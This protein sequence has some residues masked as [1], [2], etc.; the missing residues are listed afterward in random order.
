MRSGRHMRD[1][2]SFESA[3]PPAVPRPIAVFALW[4]DSPPGYSAARDS[5]DAAPAAEGAVQAG[6]GSPGESVVR[7]APT[8]DSRYIAPTERSDCAPLAARRPDSEQTRPTP[9]TVRTS[10]ERPFQTPGPVPVRRPGQAERP[11]APLPSSGRVP[12]TPSGRSATG[13]R[14][15]VCPVSHPGGRRLVRVQS[16]PASAEVG[17]AGRVGKR[18][19]PKT[20]SAGESTS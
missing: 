20:S 8:P 15:G 16:T 7:P 2:G 10:F 3:R 6:P 4:N 13:V 11:R 12:D 19:S 5:T 9:D 18:G 14:C 17:Y 1:T